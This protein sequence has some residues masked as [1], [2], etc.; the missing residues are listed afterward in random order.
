V[1]IYREK[2][3][4]VS[5]KVLVPIRE[6]PKVDLIFIYHDISKQIYLLQ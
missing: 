3:V 1:D 6:H 2:P 5:I 4:R